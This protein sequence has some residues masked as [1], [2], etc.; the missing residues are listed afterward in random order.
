MK[1]ALIVFLLLA[2]P[3]SAQTPPPSNYCAYAMTEQMQRDLL[4]YMISVKTEGQSSTQVMLPMIQLLNAYEQKCQEDAK[5][6][7]EPQK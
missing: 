1:R 5:K 6:A 3:V 4:S 2:S 7:G